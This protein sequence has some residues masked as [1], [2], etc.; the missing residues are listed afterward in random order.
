MDSNLATAI[1]TS[2]A[3]AGSS[4]GVAITA[5]VLQNKRIDRVEGKLDKIETALEML[6]GAL[7]ELDKR[8]SILEDR[9]PKR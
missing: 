9:L 8:L 6:T 2:I 7:H 3:T 5:L 1:V 4:A